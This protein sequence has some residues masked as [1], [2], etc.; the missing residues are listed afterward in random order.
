[1]KISLLTFIQDERPRVVVP[2]H[3]DH[4]VPVESPPAAL[5]HSVAGDGGRGVTGPV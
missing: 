2:W 4:I 5:V 1:M 3:G